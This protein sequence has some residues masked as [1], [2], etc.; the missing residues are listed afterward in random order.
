[1]SVSASASTICAG[2]SVTF[3]AV[4]VNGGTAPSYQWKKNGINIGTNSSTYSSNS[5]ANNDVI[6]CILTSNASCVTGNPATSN[7]ITM[8][9]QSCNNQPPVINNQG[10]YLNEN[11]VSGTLVGQVVATDP[12][13]GQTLSYSIVSGN[14]EGA[15]SINSSTGNLYVSNSLAI[16]Y[17]LYP[18]FSLI[19]KVQ[20]NASTPLSS[21]AVV[22]VNLND[23]NEPPVMGDDM[24]SIVENLSAGSIIGTIHATDPDIGQTLT[25]SIL[26]GN[27]SSAFVINPYNGVLLVANPSALNYEQTPVFTLVVKATDNGTGN[28]STQSYITIDLQDVNEPPSALSFTCFINENLPNGSVIGTVYAF[29]P[30]AGQNLTYIIQSGNTNNAFTI[31]P[32]SGQIT[33]SNSIALNFEETPDFYLIIRVMDNG[34]PQQSCLS[35]VVVHLNDLNEAPIVFDDAFSID[36]NSP[37]GTYIGTVVANDPDNGQLLT[38]SIL[39]GNI[40]GAFSIDPATG[41]IVVASSAALNFE[42]TPVYILIVKV[43]DNGTGYLSSQ[44]TITIDINNLNELPVINDQYFSVFKYAPNGTVVDTVIASDPDVGQ[45]LNYSIMSGNMNGAFQI[46]PFLGILTVANSS[47]INPAF[48]YELIIRVT[49]NGSGY[50]FKEG[51]ITVKVNDNNNQG[52]FNDNLVFFISENSVSGT[53]VGNIADPNYPTNGSKLNYKFISGNHDDV[54]AIDDQSGTITINRSEILDYEKQSVFPLVILITQSGQLNNAYIQ[55]VKV[56]LIDIF[57][58]TSSDRTERESN[59]NPSNLSEIDQKYLFPYFG[60]V[61]HDSLNSPISLIAQNTSKLF[62]GIDK[63]LNFYPNPVTADRLMIE[64]RDHTDTDFLFW[65]YDVS[66]KQLFS[67]LY[68]QQSTVEVDLRPFPNGTYIIIV[69]INDELYSKKIIKL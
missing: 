2:A 28:L 68:L 8:T 42:I 66:G 13:L 21:Q 32:L 47:M 67:Q 30:D 65:L 63:F 14:T 25:Y 26:S 43:Q 29:D 59:V 50:L 37:T 9:V 38:Y 69:K 16:N 41:D 7:N 54:F 20:D 45:I 61:N 1:V 23:I 6:T 3:T 51:V 60:L 39:S 11:T 44:C 27:T 40:G 49:D 46:D 15:F 56:K 64:T 36:E 19:V 48:L 5:L 24:F 35:S 55:S 58:L 34:S 10:F 53:F 52:F 22:T 33:V 62:L 57:E 31:N 12:N 4:P 17:E 18:V